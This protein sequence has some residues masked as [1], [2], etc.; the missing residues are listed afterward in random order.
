MLLAWWRVQLSRTAAAIAERGVARVCG[1]GRAA[2]EAV[3]DG[4][5]EVRGKAQRVRRDGEHCVCD[6]G[7]RGSQG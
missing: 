5:H 2:V 6:H 3:V 1:R 7:G 4:L